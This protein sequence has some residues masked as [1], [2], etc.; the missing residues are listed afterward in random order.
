MREREVE[1]FKLNGSY[2][3][4]LERINSERVNK[5][6]NLPCC[7]NSAAMDDDNVDN[8]IEYL[9]VHRMGILIAADSD[10]KEMVKCL[11]E[12]DNNTDDDKTR[13]TDG[14][15]LYDR[16]I[17]WDNPVDYYVGITEQFKILNSYYNNNNKM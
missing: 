12:T 11:I 10:S 16:I 3:E 4:L 6:K 15:R 5:I 7:E 2:K 1:W 17:M 9:P 14:D 13:I 8:Y